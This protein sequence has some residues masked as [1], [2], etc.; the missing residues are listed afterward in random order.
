[1]NDNRLLFRLLLL[2]NDRVVNDKRLLLG[3]LALNR[4]INRNSTVSHF[5]RIF[6]R[7]ILRLL[8]HFL[9]HFQD[10]AIGGVVDLF[11]FLKIDPGIFQRNLIK[12]HNTNSVKM[13]EIP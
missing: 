2:L 4:R 13:D 8:V 3:S 12:C 7:L 11:V 6:I 5:R 9:K 10:F 1:M